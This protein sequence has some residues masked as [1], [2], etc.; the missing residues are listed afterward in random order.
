MEIIC[1]EFIGHPRN[2][3]GKNHHKEHSGNRLNAS[4]LHNALI[5]KILFY[6]IYI[7]IYVC[8]FHLFVCFYLFLYLHDIYK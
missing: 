1:R 3:G 5:L 8:F 6:Y 7:Y 4:K 2:K